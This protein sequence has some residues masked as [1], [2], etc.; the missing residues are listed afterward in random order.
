MGFV[1][2]ITT[3][4]DTMTFAGHESG[5]QLFGVFQ[6]SVLHNVVH[7]LFGAVGLAVAR[8]TTGS[9]R[10]PQYGGVAYLVL[11]VYGVIVDHDHGANVVAVDE[12][13]S[14]LHLGL[15]IGMILL[16]GVARGL[17]TPRGAARAPGTPTS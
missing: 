10:Y 1:V 17:L 3:D 16:A 4:L 12:A 11:W 2:G 13:D 7:L 15:G 5:A 14:W 6:V 9:I 8:S